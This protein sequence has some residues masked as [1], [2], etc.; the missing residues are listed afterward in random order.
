MGMT[1]ESFSPAFV[2]EALGLALPAGAHQDNPNLPFTF[3]TTDSRKIQPGCLFVALKGEQFDGHDFI[4]NAVDNGARGVIMRRGAAI[5]PGPTTRLFQVDDT[6]VAYR[7]LGAA[8]RKKFQI[9]LIA[10]AG[11]VGKTT[12]KEILTAILQGKYPKVLKTQ[13]SQNGFIGIPMTLLEL[14]PEHG[15]AVIEVGID[16]IGA[17]AKHMPMVAASVAVLTAIGPEHLEKLRD[18]PTIAHEEGVALQQVSDSGGMTVINL[19][20]EWIRPYAVALHKGRRICFTLRDTKLPHSA[21]GITESDVL[22]GQLSADQSK[23]T[24]NG[25]GLQKLTLK[26]PLLGSHNASNLM[27]A[28]ALAAGLGLSAREIEAGLQTFQGA[29]G[30]SEIR[31]LAGS[32]RVL[33]DYYNAN[34]SSTEAGLELLTQISQGKTRWACLGDMLELGPNEDQFHRDL[35]KKILSLKLENVL[36]YGPRMKWLQDELSKKGFAGRL[37]HFASHEELA[38]QLLTT[39]QPGDAVIIKGSRGMKM[40]EVWKR[41]S[42]GFGK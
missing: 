40:E 16:E 34:P 17:M 11:S 8:W 33:C 41:F 6:L 24:L 31:E 28:V 12:T 25:L 18:I 30:R 19:D 35:S 10:I 15:A 3:V 5:I 23:I 14:R 20:D 9:P 4:Q 7:R 36:L 37:A 22:N 39:V 26:L 42:E 29:S 1:Q 32:T 13:G 21:R 38:R 2:S 27:A